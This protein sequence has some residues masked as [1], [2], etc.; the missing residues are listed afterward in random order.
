VRCL[1]PLQP[2]R[3]QVLG[4]AG[5]VAG[6]DGA[7]RDC[8]DEVIAGADGVHGVVQGSPPEGDA[9]RL[10]NSL[11]RLHE[12]VQPTNGLENPTLLSTFHR[13]SSCSPPP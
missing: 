12:I 10:S 11:D 4:H 1:Q 2:E 3:V 5:E 9:T 6:Q 13:R 8:L 7:S